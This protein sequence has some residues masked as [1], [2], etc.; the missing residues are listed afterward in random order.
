MSSTSVGT[1]NRAV[2][3]MEEVCACCIC[4]NRNI[5]QVD[6]E[7]NLCR[8]RQC[9]YVFDSPRPSE[10]EIVAFY[11]RAEKYDSWLS[12]VRG[13]DDLWQR[14]LKMLLPYRVPG[15]LLDIGAGI[16]QFLHHAKPHFTEVA[17]TE[18]SQSACRIAAERYGLKILNGQVEELELP[19]G[20]CDNV[21]L[22]HVLEHVP[23]PER[24]MRKCRDLLRPDGVL[25]IAVPNDV[26]GWGSL[27]KK[28]GRK[29]GLGPFQKFSRVLGIS[30]AG[31]SK[32]IHLSHFTPQVLRTLVRNAGFE[33]V[34]EGL[35]PYYVATGLRKL[36][37]ST[38]YSVHRALFALFGVNRYETIWLIARKDKERGSRSSS[39]EGKQ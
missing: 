16:G 17:G 23:H 11:S 4:A 31:T 13:R 20:S 19:D 26:L 27:I 33:I 35:D 5:E 18:V 7:C 37:H 15:N 34:Q 29:I 36:S 1:L 38:Y 9:G 14:R 39:P 10:E 28:L 32:E 22:F 25:L 12:D 6:P 21:T 30:R 8:C 24:L 3:L 2:E